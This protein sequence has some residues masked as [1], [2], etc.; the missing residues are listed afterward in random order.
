MADTVRIE[1]AEF[2]VA[3]ASSGAARVAVSDALG[4]LVGELVVGGRQR[5]F[6]NAAIPFARRLDGTAIEA[7][8]PST[9]VDHADVGLGD[10]CLLTVG[11]DAWRGAALVDHGVAWALRPGAVRTQSGRDARGP[12]LETTW[13]VRAGAIA[14]TFVRRLTP[15]ED[16]AVDARFALINDG[17]IDLPLFW[18]SHDMVPLSDAATFAL[19]EG[20]P[21]VVYAAL[22]VD[23]AEAGH[24]WP[25]LRLRDGGALDVSSPA[26]AEAK[27]GR[28]FAAKIFSRD[29]CGALIVDDGHGA[30]ALTGDG[31]RAGLW[32]NRGG[33]KPATQPAH[34]RYQ[35]ACPERGLGGATDEVSRGDGATLPPGATRSWSLRYAPL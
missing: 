17:A 7:G 21:L 33:W 4:G 9:Y 20:T 31:T 29:P 27:L 22:G 32:I 2:V 26:R 1:G 28:P 35:S 8:S 16:G 3:A 34:V 19:P 30:F 6:R 13:I 12:F 24:A 18:S 25:H 11:A 15:H 14:C 5:L 10:Q 23:V